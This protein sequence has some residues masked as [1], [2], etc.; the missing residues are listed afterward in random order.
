[1]EEPNGFTANVG[2]GAKYYAMNNLYVKVEARYRYLNRL[3]SDSNQNLNTAETTLG[4]GW[5]F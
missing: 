4:I 2:I 1:V 3:V 5:Q